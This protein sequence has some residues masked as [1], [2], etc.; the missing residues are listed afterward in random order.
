MLPFFWHGIPSGHD[1]EFH[2]NSWIEVVDHWKQGVWYPHWAAWAHN[3]Y[4]E[5]RFIFYPPISWSLGG[6]LGLVLPWK[7]VSGAYIWIVLTLSGCSMFSLA[8][9]W[10]PRADAI[11]AAA[12]YAANPYHLVIVYWRSAM[13]ELFAAAYL[14]L[15]LLVILRSE[16]EGPGIVV[17]LGLLIA[18]GWLTNIPSAVMMN[19]SLALLV[20]CVAIAR[21][22]FSIIR[23]A[24][25]AAV[26]GAALAG[27]YLVPVVHQRSWVHIG[28]VLA[29][30]VRP[31]E[32]FLFTATQD[33]DHN[34]FNLLVSVV[35]VW[36]IALLAGALFV[37]RRLRK[38]AVWFL[39]SAW[40]VF[41]VL[42][43]MRFTLPL[44]MHLPELRFVQFPWRWLLC[45]NVPFVL[46]IAL[47]L[48]RWWLRGLVYAVAVGGV[49]WA[50]YSVQ[51]PWWDKAA[52]IQEML[53]NQ[54]DGIGYEGTDEYVP[55]TADADEV[56]DKAPQVRFVGTGEAEIK[57]ISWQ[58]ESRTLTAKAGTPGKLVLRL[59][60]YPLWRVRVNDRAVATENEAP[61]GQMV[62]PISAGDNRIQILFVD[63]CDRML[64]LTVSLLA[65][66]AAAWFA[67]S[68][69]A[70]RRVA[71]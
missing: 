10:L 14:P 55:V 71:V 38:Q 17:P 36:Q 47:S 57:I 12:I 60:N 46:A 48:P 41:C 21:R 31:Q 27:F 42:L 30:G 26:L 32:S 69:R 18:L 54:H 43:M 2:F 59:F 7:L 37:S 56:D 24:A 22:S 25:V 29:P 15:L 16:E 58:A 20:L 49:L 35:A 28:Q 5:A 1:F 64:G 34:R 51:P 11:F 23:Y 40:S 8:K 13:A 70:V 62:I 44:W 45:L 6:L 63:S 50:G 4:G 33:A 9:R 39:I 68:R 65:S 53:D 52:D 3:R 67:I 19:Y 66:V 61:T